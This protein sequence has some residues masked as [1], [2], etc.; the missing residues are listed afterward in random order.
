MKRWYPEGWRFTIE[1]VR[2]GKENRAE[3]CRLGLE[4]GDTFECA[5]ETPAGFCPTSF[6]KLFPA[7]EAVR[8][9]GDL[10]NLGGTGP[11]ETLCMCPDGVVMF[12][13]KGEPVGGA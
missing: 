7:M 8:C 4:V 12:R 13:V 5:Y 6:I 3:E 10:R 11:A 1:V 9:G 2:V